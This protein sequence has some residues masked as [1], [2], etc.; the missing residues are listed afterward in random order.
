MIKIYDLNKN[1]IGG[2]ENLKET[3]IESTLSTGDKV[4]SFSYHINNKIKLCEEMYIQTQTD[5]FVIKEIVKK[6]KGF[7]EIKA[8]LNLEELEGKP[9]EA[10]ESTDHTITECANLALV[11]TGWRVGECLITKKRNIKLTNTDSYKILEQLCKSYNAEIKFDTLNKIVYFAEEIGEDR[12]VYFSDSLNLKSVDIS[13]DT[14][15][16]YTRIIPIGKDGL[17]IDDING[18]KE[19]LENYQYSNKIKTLRWTDDKYEDKQALKEDA[20][21]KL[22]ELSKPKRSFKASVIDI[23]KQSP[24]YN[25]LEYGLGDTVTIIS[26][27]ERIREKQ[28]IVKITEYP[29]NYLKNTCEISNTVLTF[30][31]MQ[32][33]LFDA[34]ETVENV[35]NDNGTLKGS[36]V[37]KIVIEQIPDFESECSRIVTLY[38]EENAII[39][40]L[41]TDYLYV[42]G[43]LAAVK[44]TVGEINANYLKATEADIKYLTAEKADI[45]YLTIET[46]EAE[47]IKVGV[48]QGLEG[49]FEKLKADNAEFVTVVTNQITAI[50]GKF[51]SL[52]TK[53]ATI[54]LA[55]IKE[56]SIT[57]AMIGTGVVGSAQIAD[58][59]ITDAKIVTLTANKITAGKIDA[60]EIEVINLK[61]DNITVGTINGNQI[62][63]GA[64]DA[65]KLSDALS[66][67]IKNAIDDV[68]KALKEAGLAN[69]NSEEAI[70]IANTAKTLTAVLSKETKTVPTD[71]AGN[72][73]IYTGCESRIF[74]YY[75]TED[76]TQEAEYKIE[77]SQDVTGIWTEAEKKYTVQKL[78]ADAGYIDITASYKKIA[79]TKRFDISKTRR[80]EPGQTGA[81][82]AT[83]PQGTPGAKG[84]DGKTSY[85]H[86]RYSQN[87]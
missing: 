5:E 15:D 30:E 1:L 82:G 84:A 65:S 37:D 17:K 68:D 76:V 34:A 70:E 3:Q 8:V 87:A 81:T 11:G 74:V 71:A 20:E 61:A 35:T 33:K 12:G 27:D 62:A 44:A 9:W 46:A 50:D 75:G 56:G 77:P 52:D 16:F 73:G 29:D 4:L 83:G 24:K 53:F 57:T 22:N 45:K 41:E 2:T 18:G 39:K 79:V 6:Q 40:N 43:E 69:S 47:Y 72:N 10:F 23:A 19:Y 42:S 58:G 86:I 25:I 54:D 7:R 66:G 55:N 21:Y 63:P 51:E 28:R 80:G 14:Y 64:I 78:N 60:A 31:E 36:S 32:Q 67:D 48:I 38:V 13:S 49:E 59:S 85:F 26:S